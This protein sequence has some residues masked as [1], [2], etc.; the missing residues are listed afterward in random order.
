MTSTKSAKTIKT[1]INSGG[2][3]LNLEDGTSCVVLGGSSIATLSDKGEVKKHPFYPNSVEDYIKGIVDSGL[4]YGKL[5]KGKPGILLVA[6]PGAFQNEGAIAGLPPNFHRV[7]EDAKQRGMPNLFF[8]QLIEEELEKRGYEQVKAYGYNDTVPALTATLC[9]PNAE[10]VLKDF[11]K[12]LGTNDR[13]EYAIT[14]LINGTGTGEGAI[15]PNNHKIV[16]A[17]KGHL[18]PDYLWYELNPFFKY[19]IRFPQIGQ[20][21]T[22]ERLVAGGPDRRE[23]RHFTKILNVILDILN[24]QN[25][26]EVHEELSQ[27]LEFKNYQELLKADGENGILKIK[28][29]TEG[30]SSLV[31]L[32]QAIG[33]GSHL[34]VRLRNIFAKAIGASIARMHFA[35]GEMPDPPLKTFVGPNEIRSSVLGFIRSDGSTTAL[36]SGQP[37]AWSLLENNAKAYAKALLGD[38]KHLFQVMDIN[39]TFPNI[40]PDFGGLPALAAQKL[41]KF[42]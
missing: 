1:K 14:Y 4:S 17:E 12:K 8:R 24:D 18:T 31:E 28:F 40:H 3:S 30:S 27:A 29:T 37:E 32:G 35:I 21:R 42:K 41:S 19:I 23:P 25:R 22:I 10:E 26:R 20:N 16:T 38:K 6:A 39:S 34:A 2:D 11:E 33:A 5:Q 9:Q 36:F 13:S 7:Q 15:Y